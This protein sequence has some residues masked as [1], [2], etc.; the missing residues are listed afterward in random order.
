MEFY[1]WCNR[2]YGPKIARNYYEMLHSPLGPYLIKAF[3]ETVTRRTGCV[4]Q[5]DPDTFPITKEIRTFMTPYRYR[6]KH[7][8]G[9]ESY[10]DIADSHM[11]VTINSTL[12][13][14]TLNCIEYNEC[15]W[16]GLWTKAS[17]LPYLP[18]YPVKLTF[19][20]TRAYV[21]DDGKM[22]FNKIWV[23]EWTTNLAFASRQELIDFFQTTSPDIDYPNTAV[24]NAP[25]RDET[26][27]R[28]EGEPS[29]RLTLELP[30]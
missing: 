6:N 26:G 3:E 11:C 30:N 10:Y 15:I 18:F 5:K 24:P 14:E 27:E 1:S 19:K 9:E 13:Q 25:N 2:Y 29:P 28:E 22:R 8:V 20:L 21:D 23:R 7:W 17:L 12:G 16:E 4:Y